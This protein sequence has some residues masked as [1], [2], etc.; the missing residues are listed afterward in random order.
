MQNNKKQNEHTV[1]HKQRIRCKTYIHKHTNKHKA[2]ENRLQIENV[3]V[4]IENRSYIVNSAVNYSVFSK[5][6]LVFEVSTK[7]RSHSLMNAEYVS[8]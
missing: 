4:C 1:D 5:F 3:D 7:T 6:N 2:N 8:S